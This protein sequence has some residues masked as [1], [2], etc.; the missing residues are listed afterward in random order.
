MGGMPGLMR[1]DRVLGVRKYF[2]LVMS[3]EQSLVV[4]MTMAQDEKARFAVAVVST[5]LLNTVIHVPRA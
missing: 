5:Y 3:R 1:R 4:L 2:T